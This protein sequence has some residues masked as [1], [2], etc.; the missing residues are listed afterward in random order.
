MLKEFFA[1]GIA[2]FI[3][4]DSIVFDENELGRANIFFS[5]LLH[6]GYL[7]LSERIEN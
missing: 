4:D 3:P 6:A 7:T 1:T 2:T 5:L